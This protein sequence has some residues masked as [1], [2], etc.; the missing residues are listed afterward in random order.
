MPLLAD[1]AIA[2]FTVNHK[3]LE[4]ALAVNP[5]L[6]TA[7]NSVV[8]YEKGAQIAKEAYKTGEPIIDVALRLTEMDR[9]TLTRL[10][11]PKLLTGA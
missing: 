8:G 4:K 11:D 3:Q 7:L 9:D 5:I 1:K 2:G 10:M 6:V